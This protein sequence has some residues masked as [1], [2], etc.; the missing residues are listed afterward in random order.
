MNFIRVNG[1]SNVAAAAHDGVSLYMLFHRSSG[2]T[3]LY[4]FEGVPES[5]YRDM[6]AQPIDGSV[7]KHFNYLIRPRFAGIKVK[8]EHAKA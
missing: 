4:R 5:E 6:M 2:G 8:E 1:S 3:A 7:G